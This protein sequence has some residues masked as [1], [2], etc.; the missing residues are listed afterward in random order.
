V[1]VIRA[2][3]KIPESE[4]QPAIFLVGPTPRDSHTKSWRPEAVGHLEDLGFDGWVFVP[5]RDNWQIDYLDQVEWEHEG[6]MLAEAFGCVAA[7]VPRE[8][9]KMPAFTT[10]VEFGMYVDCGAF[11]YGRPDGAPK[12]RY[13]DWAYAK[14]T[15]REPSVLLEELMGAAVEC[16]RR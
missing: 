3:E 10:N 14:Y 7:W 15:G 4:G 2:D 12:T 5:E 16:A 1:R 9:E 11:V 8:L 6:L 13:L